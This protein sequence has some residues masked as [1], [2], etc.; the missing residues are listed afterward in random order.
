MSLSLFSRSASRLTSIVASSSPVASRRVAK[1]QCSS[2]WVP[3]YRPIWVCVLPTSIARSMAR[4]LQRA[5][6]DDSLIADRGERVGDVH[7]ELRE[8]LE[9]EAARAH[10]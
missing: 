4:V 1:R 8:R 5:E 7:A 3:L 2:S 6:P 10:L 9:H